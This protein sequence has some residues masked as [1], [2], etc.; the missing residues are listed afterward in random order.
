MQKWESLVTLGKVC[1]SSFDRLPIQVTRQMND[2]VAFKQ[3]VQNGDDRLVDRSRAAAAA[4]KQD[5]R[6]FT[7][8]AKVS[9][10]I[11]LGP[12]HQILPQRIASHFNFLLLAEKRA[13]I[14]HA[15]RNFVRE[16]SQGL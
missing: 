1:C 16:A 9:Q 13:R 6:L 3:V 4:S 2:L 11:S 12:L 14:F 8:E 10:S 5:H 15:D 7:G